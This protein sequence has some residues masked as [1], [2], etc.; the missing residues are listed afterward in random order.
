[1]PSQTIAPAHINQY[2]ELTQPHTPYCHAYMSPHTHSY[3][4]YGCMLMSLCHKLFM[5][6]H[7]VPTPCHHLG[8][9]LATSLGFPPPYMF[10]ALIV[11]YFSF[12]LFVFDNLIAI[13]FGVYKVEVLKPTLEAIWPNFGARL[14]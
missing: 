6:R 10:F 13:S 5:T 14:D 7:H 2:H 4:P 11:P 3:T 1:M 9:M 12:V 8:S